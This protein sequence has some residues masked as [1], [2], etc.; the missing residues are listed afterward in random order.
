H[1][2]ESFLLSTLRAEDHPVRE[3]IRLFH[4][5]RLQYVCSSRSFLMVVIIAMPEDVPIR[6]TP[7]SMYFL[8]VAKSFIPPEAFIVKVSPTSSTIIFTACSVAP[9]LPNPVDVLT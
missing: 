2:Q 4:L 7:K 1:F 9:A 6:L 8:A 3:P 5:E